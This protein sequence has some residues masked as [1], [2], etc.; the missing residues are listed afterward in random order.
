MGVGARGRATE[1][2][3]P[4]G[5]IKQVWESDGPIKPDPYLKTYPWAK[6]L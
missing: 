2:H 1:R 6:G 5:Q 3:E 4:S